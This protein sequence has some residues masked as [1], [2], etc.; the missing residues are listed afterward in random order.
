MKPSPSALSEAWEI[1]LAATG[2]SRRIPGDGSRQARASHPFR[3][4]NEMPSPQ[5]LMRPIQLRY[6]D[7]EHKERTL[8]VVQE[9]FAIGR[10]ASCQFRPRDG[11]VSRRHAEIF[12]DGDQVF[13]HDL[14][15]RN[16]T[17]LNEE[18]V[19]FP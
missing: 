4:R 3:R 17:W 14:N 8:T 15:S 7:G 16:G 12:R 10:D 5:T 2:S 18:R 19:L 1:G 13:L 6:T 11:L 9:R